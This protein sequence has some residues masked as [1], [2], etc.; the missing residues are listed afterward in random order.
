MNK[1]TPADTRISFQQKIGLIAFGLFLTLVLIET[2]LRLGG[3]VSISLR[4]LRNRVSL[5]GGEVRILCLGE[6]TT[7]D[8]YPSFLEASLNQR[9]TGIKFSVIDEGMSGTNTWIILSGLESVLDEYH[10]DIV[11]TMMGIN[12]RAATYTPDDSALYLKAGNF[13]RSFRVYKL[14]RLYL[15]IDF[16]NLYSHSEKKTAS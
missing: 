16:K 1:N 4:D 14:I 15:E 8:Q 3:I 6:S 13:L 7:A 10:P 12:D 9:N 11:I 5:K 2:G